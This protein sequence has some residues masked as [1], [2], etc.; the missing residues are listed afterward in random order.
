MSQMYNFKCEYCDGAVEEKITTE[1][2]W[3]K[4]ELIVL[5]NVPI[6]ICSKCKN[7]YYSAEVLEKLEE[8]FQNRVKLRKIE[9]PVYDFSVRE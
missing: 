4:G 7:R 6:G 5:K 9:V 8:A 1:D 2:F 3:H